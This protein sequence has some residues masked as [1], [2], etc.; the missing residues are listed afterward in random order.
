[1]STSR[2]KA[3]IKRHHQELFFLAALETKVSEGAR[4]KTFIWTNG[5]KI[6]SIVVQETQAE[7]VIIEEAEEHLSNQFNTRPVLLGEML[8]ISNYQEWATSPKTN[9]G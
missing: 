6:Y 7:A 9:L 3:T 4:Y 8:T 5:V 2:K 1:M